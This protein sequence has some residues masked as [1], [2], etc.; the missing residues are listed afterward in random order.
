MA[1]NT[2]ISVL[3]CKFRHLATAEVRDGRL[4]GAGVY[5]VAAAGP[6]WRVV[7]IR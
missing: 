3:F 4:Q 7:E 5:S 1:N 6:V 2:D